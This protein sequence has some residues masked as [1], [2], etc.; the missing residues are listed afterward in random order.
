MR[1]VCAGCSQRAGGGIGSKGNALV[2]TGGVGRCNFN[3]RII[4]NVDGDDGGRESGCFK[5]GKS[6]GQ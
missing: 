2:K 6:L 4:W 1:L 5:H 3:G